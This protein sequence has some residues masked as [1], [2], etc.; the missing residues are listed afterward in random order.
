MNEIDYAVLA[1][2]VYNRETFVGMF[3]NGSGASPK[4][5]SSTYIGS[6][7]SSQSYGSFLPAF[8]LS[9]SD[10]FFASVYRWPAP[11]GWSGLNVSA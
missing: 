6:Y 9:F 7:S 4:V 3:P 10:D 1:M 2:D 8:N 11:L 5:G